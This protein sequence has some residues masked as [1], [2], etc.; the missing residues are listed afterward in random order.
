MRMFVRLIISLLAAVCGAAL[1][2]GAVALV[3]AL[4][5]QDT[6]IGGGLLALLAALIGAALGA[7]A[8]FRR[9]GIRAKS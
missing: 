7:V 2:F 1:G 5:R 8:T 6:G 4:F 3:F 9:L